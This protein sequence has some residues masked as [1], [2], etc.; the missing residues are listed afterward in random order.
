MCLAQVRQKDRI[1]HK[2]VFVNANINPSRFAVVDFCAH[3]FEAIHIDF[4]LHETGMSYAKE[5][6]HK[7]T[8][9]DAVFGKG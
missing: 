1:R 8:P 2:G 6:V 7:K 5:H 9:L 3:S 4:V